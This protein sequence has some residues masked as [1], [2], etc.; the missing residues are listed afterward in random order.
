V[1]T[2]DSAVALAQVHPVRGKTRLNAQ[3]RFR[4]R[5]GDLCED[6][7]PLKIRSSYSGNS[8]NGA[9]RRRDETGHLKN[10]A[11]NSKSFIYLLAVVVDFLRCWKV[12]ALNVIFIKMD[13][14]RH[15]RKH[16]TYIN[17]IRLRITLFFLR[18]YLAKVKQSAI[19]TRENY[20]PWAC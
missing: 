3:C 19:P 17:I 1:H 14:L 20:E 5:L 12:R 9:E 18:N 4:K 11:L 2:I 10:R 15:L 6:P 16:N 8:Q 7:S 13:L